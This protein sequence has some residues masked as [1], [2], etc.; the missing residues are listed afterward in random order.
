MQSQESLPMKLAV[1]LPCYNEE[2]AI[3]GVVVSYKA[4]LPDADIYVYDN[5]STDQTARVAAEAGAI[6][7]HEPRKGKGNVVRRMFADVDADVYLMADGDGT[8]DSEAAP[9]LIERLVSEN[10]DMVVGARDPEDHHQVSR[11]GH[12][13]GNEI[14]N[15]LVRMIFSGGINDMLSGYRAFSRRFVK[16]FPAFSGGFEIET[17]LT[18]H[19]LQLRLPVAEMPTRYFERAE[20]TQSKLSTYKDGLRILNFILYL[21]KEGKPFLFFSIL[22]LG[23]VCLSLAFGLPVVLEYFDTGL[24]PRFPTLFVSVGTMLAAVISFACGVILDSV[25]RGR[26]E[27]KRLAYLT[28][29]RRT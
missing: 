2:A 10:L 15:R 16:T 13:F 19:A 12:R 1:L 22:A 6:V 21:F 25:S 23:L 26:Q 14:L 9:A 24:V 18:I 8:Y 11:K 28:Y 27:I 5:N 29:G 17:E 20:G 4:A 7:R 3:A